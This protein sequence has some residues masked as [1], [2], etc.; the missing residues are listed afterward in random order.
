[1]KTYNESITIFD[2]KIICFNRKEVELKEY[3]LKLIKSGVN[4]DIDD[5]FKIRN[6]KIEGQFINRYFLQDFKSDFKYQVKKFKYYKN[7]KRN[8]LYLKYIN[9][10]KIEECYYI[11]GV[12]NGIFKTWYENRNIKSEINFVNGIINGNS[13]EYYMWSGSVM[14]SNIKYVNG[15]KNGISFFYCYK[16]CI[17]YK[18]YYDND[19]L[20]IRQSL[21]FN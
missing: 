5:L 21:K 20:I 14:E 7:C 12:L 1:M 13:K 9:D 10:I 8:G 3:N 2:M 17:K 15:K 19:N 11:N 16:G 6:V 18:D 4:F